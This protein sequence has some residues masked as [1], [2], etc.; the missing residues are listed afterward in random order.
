M[1]TRTKCQGSDSKDKRVLGRTAEEFVRAS[2]AIRV[3]GYYHHAVW[4]EGSHSR[5]REKKLQ[6]IITANTNPRIYRQSQVPVGP[7][8]HFPF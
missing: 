7:P 4:V 1:D 5:V 6:E 8:M 3:V 2:N